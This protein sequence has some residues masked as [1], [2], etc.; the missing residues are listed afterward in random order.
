MGLGVQAILAE[1]ATQPRH[2]RDLHVAVGEPRLAGRESS[3]Q[4]VGVCRCDGRQELQVACF[5]I[6]SVSAGRQAF[7]V[8]N[9]KPCLHGMQ[10]ARGRARPL[11]HAGDAAGEAIG[12]IA[13]HFVQHRCQLRQRQRLRLVEIP[14]RDA[15]LEQLAER[16]WQLGGRQGNRFA[17]GRALVGRRWQTV[18]VE[19]VARTGRRVVVGDFVAAPPR[20]EMRDGRERRPRRF[21]KSRIAQT[22]LSGFVDDHACLQQAMHAIRFVAAEIA[23]IAP[24]VG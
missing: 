11:V 19:H 2:E 15:A 21:A 10:T 8:A 4:P 6:V 5:G 9:Q 7:D 16:R 14:A 12:A 1:R 17:I 23:G 22:M 20:L 13:E 18:R 3:H 24:E